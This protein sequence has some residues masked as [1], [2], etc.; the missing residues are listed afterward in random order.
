MISF[1]K[2]GSLLKTIPL[3]STDPL[4]LDTY[5][6]ILAK[7]DVF[8]C[9]LICK[10]SQFIYKSDDILRMRYEIDSST[11]HVYLLRDPVSRELVDDIYFFQRQIPKEKNKIIFKDDSVISKEYVK[12]RH[13]HFEYVCNEAEM[14][15]NKNLRK[16][17]LNFEGRKELEIYLVALISLAGI[18][19]VI[20]TIYSR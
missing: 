17:I 10:D 13:L 12:N 2:H 5:E 11:I 4:S 16:K 14:F 7:E 20:F 19:I 8:M 1:V 18:L 6:N 15:E 3:S 9:M